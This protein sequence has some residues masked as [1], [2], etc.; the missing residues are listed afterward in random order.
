MVGIAFGV[1]CLVKGY[2]AFSCRY[3]PATG[4]KH[5]KMIGK[6]DEIDLFCLFLRNYYYR[7]FLLLKKAPPL[8]CITY[9][10]HF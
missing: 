5:W 2:T 8:F 4:N 10:V 9:A 1:G 3:W 7:D 6:Y